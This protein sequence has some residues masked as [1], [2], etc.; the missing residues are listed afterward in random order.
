MSILLKECDQ[1]RL[2][3]KVLYIYDLLMFS[4]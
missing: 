3:E 4:C 2:K 1:N